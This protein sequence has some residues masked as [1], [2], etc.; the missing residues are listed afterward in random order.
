MIVLL[1]SALS[2]AVILWVNRQTSI[3]ESKHVADVLRIV[4][5]YAGRDAQDAEAAA[6]FRKMCREMPAEQE[7][8]NA[9]RHYAQ[10]LMASGRQS[11]VF[12]LLSQ[13]SRVGDVDPGNEAQVSF[14]LSQYVLL[15]AAA[16]EIGMLNVSMEY[17]TRGMSLAEEYGVERS[18]A[19]FL[20]NLGVCYYRMNELEK[21]KS[22]FRRSLAINKKNKN[23]YDI[24]LNYNNLSEVDFSEGRLDDALGNALYALQYLDGADV[25]NT[26]VKNA[27]CYI[28]SQIAKIYLKKRDLYMARS[29]VENAIRLQVRSGFKADLFESCMI[30]SD[31]FKQSGELDSA[32]VWVN[33]GLRAIDGLGLPSQRSQALERLSNIERESGN[34]E[35]SIRHLRQAFD[36][37]DSLALSENRNRME[38]C[39]QLYEVERKNLK[40]SSFLSRQNPVVVFAI[41]VAV[42]LV[43]ALIMVKWA[44]DK[45]KLNH[46]LQAKMQLDSE[47]KELHNRQLEEAVRKQQELQESL[48]VSHRQLTNHT[49][50][51]LRDNEWREDIVNDM[52]R[53]LVSI[54]PR[55][56][57]LRASLSGIISKMARYK[58]NDDWTEFNYYFERVNTDFFRKL[59]KAHPDITEKQKRLCALLSLGL[60]TKEIAQITFREVRS[61][62]SSRT[63]LRKRL[64]LSN[65]VDL[66]AYMQKF[67]DVSSNV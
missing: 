11:D 8:Y 24:F 47:V 51:K 52:K 28:Q 12:N 32:R 64:G 10:A 34:Y 1:T 56:K 63:R 61:I 30:N 15:G 17:Y 29:Y 43:L 21:A 38:Q 27:T 18:T 53:L 7:V 48:D 46:T 57:E 16:D 55:S 25:N 3:G 5:D 23:N 59:T 44:L 40:D 45:R 67:T 22:F 26:E 6:V 41:G 50:Q 62:E 13:V 33:N 49:M 35:G 31:L 4:T 19:Q 65:N 66:N 20:N 60:N 58:A 9:V 14:T 2:S 42:A 54:N 39:Q 36:L 37:R